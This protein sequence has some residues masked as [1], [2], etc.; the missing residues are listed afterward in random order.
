M[1]IKRDDVSLC[2]C[3]CVQPGGTA[4]RRHQWSVGTAYI[5]TAAH[6]EAGSLHAGA[7]LPARR[8]AAYHG[9]RRNV[10]HSPSSLHL[11]LQVSAAAS[12]VTLHH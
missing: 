6:T 1:V 11:Y 9:Q 12:P 3:V 8:H 7:A 5:P 2:V 10:L 4:A